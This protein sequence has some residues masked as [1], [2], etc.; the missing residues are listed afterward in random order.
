MEKVY[1]DSK[2]VSKAG[3]RQKADAKLIEHKNKTPRRR[4]LAGLF[5]VADSFASPTDSRGS[6][7]YKPVN[8]AFEFSDSLWPLV[9]EPFA[10]GLFQCN[11][12]ALSVRQF[13]RVVAMVKLR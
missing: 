12:R 5:L 11:H 13:A 8:A 10:V 6:F 7:F 9:G 1:F 3:H 2:T 4:N